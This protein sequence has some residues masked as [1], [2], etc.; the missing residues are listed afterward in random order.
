M[1]RADHSSKEVLPCVLIRLRNLGVWGGQS[2][3]KDWRYDDDDG[4]VG[5]TLA[6]LA[7]I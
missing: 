4:E 6:P 2:P 1:R 7:V 5:S 3:C